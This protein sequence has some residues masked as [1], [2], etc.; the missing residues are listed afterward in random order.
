[1]LK[2]A[3]ILKR[4]LGSLFTDCSQSG[5]NH[6]ILPMTAI[7]EHR[8]RSAVR[9][10][11]P[12]LCGLFAIGV[13]MTIGVLPIYSDTANALSRVKKVYV[14]PLGPGKLG[15]ELRE[16]L[17][18]RLRKDGSFAVVETP[19]QADAVISGAGQVW[20]TGYDS[21][22]PRSPATSRHAVYAGFL[23][24]RVTSKDSEVLWSY[25]VTPRKFAWSGIVH[26]LADSLA[27]KLIEARLEKNDAVV[28]T[29]ASGA[30]ELTIHGAG[31]TFPAPLY[32]KWF[33]SF[34]QRN[35]NE[36]IVYDGIGSEAGI[37]MLAEGKVDFAASDMPLS[38]ERMAQ[39]G[40]KFQ[41]FPSVLGAVVPI[42][43][44]AGVSRPL[45]FTPE[46]LADIYLGKI[47]RWSDARIR[48]TNRG[49]SLPDSEIVVVH[50]SDG[51][52]TTFVWS[53]FLA[54]VSP[55]WKATV[56]SGS[57]LKW[58]VGEG[59][60]R[61]EGV[62][63]SVHQTP[64]AIGYV[65]MVFALQHQLSFGAVRNASGEFVRANLSSVT[66]AAA[67]AAGSMTSDFRISITNS[68]GAGAYPIA[69]FTWLLFPPEMD[70]R[71]KSALVELTQWI[72]TSGQ[73]ECSELGYAPLPSDVVDR[74]LRALSGM[75]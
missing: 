32:Q 65:E 14:E 64:N 46:V 31:A 33:E 73:K 17:I 16:R 50:R 39:S 27:A 61:S 63:L 11:V 26:E 58:P 43:N 74:E 54:K 15:A 35:P 36:H 45:N 1:V 4:Y 51:S 67:A 69:S 8:L 62:A 5:D 6:P 42:Y 37:R 34:Q 68:P 57:E 71:R 28:T 22:S 10:I 9:L 41:H 40:T 20:V 18:A 59:A 48:A 19:G 53:D 56:G 47:K 25:L 21:S 2:R 3:K 38:D 44:L 72:L 49:V 70:A 75:K 29:V 24:A 66:A 55:D 60:E 23:S 12:V 7:E 30:A 52:G 13:A